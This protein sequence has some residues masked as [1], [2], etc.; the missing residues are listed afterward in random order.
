MA[1]MTGIDILLHPWGVRPSYT[2]MVITEDH[3]RHGALMGGTLAHQ[4]TTTNAPSITF[5]KPGRIAYQDQQNSFRK[6]ANYLT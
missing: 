5:L 6:I 4:R 2:K 1:R 3:G